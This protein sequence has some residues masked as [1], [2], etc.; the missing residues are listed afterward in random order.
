MSAKIFSIVNQKGG[1]GKTTTSINLATI[2]AVMSKKILLI[3]LDPQGN[4]SSGLG[5][6][7][8]DRKFSSYDLLHRNE[9]IENIII[10]S[11][12]KNLDLIVSNTNLA[13]IDIEFAN[14]DSPQDRLK[15]ILIDVE[16]KYDY[17]LIDCPPSIVLMPVIKDLVVCTLGVII[18]SFSPK[19]KFKRLDLP[20]LGLPTIVSESIF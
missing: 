5:I 8:Q 7:H 3:D 1:V 14:I 4:T 16:N 13:A 12:V 9:K 11:K 19:M 10:N 6:K 20:A 17:I 2:F 15:N 18:E